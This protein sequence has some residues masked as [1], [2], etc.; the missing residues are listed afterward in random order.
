MLGHDPR[1]MS[2]EFIAPYRQGGKND[3]NAAA[4]ICETVG[5]PQMR[6]VPVK[7]VEQQ[8]VPTM[9]RLRQGL[10]EGRTALAN[11]RRGLLT[12]Y[13]VRIDVGLDRLHHALPETLDEGANGILGIA[14]EVFAGAGKQLRELYATSRPMIV[15]LWR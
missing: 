5:R 7:S 10:V 14:R 1:I 4:A 9:H 15:A 6:W 8:A 13:G 11:R 12:V 3:A 2:A